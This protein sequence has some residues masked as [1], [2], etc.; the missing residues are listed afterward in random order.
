MWKEVSVLT[1]LVGWKT[2]SLSY[3]IALLVLAS[4]EIS[5]E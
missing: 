1:V 3:E 4:S 2:D 5:V